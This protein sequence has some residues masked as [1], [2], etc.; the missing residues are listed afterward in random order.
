MKASP[1]KV[2]AYKEFLHARKYL[3]LSVC[4]SFSSV[5][6]ILLSSFRSSSDQLLFYK[7]FS[8][9]ACVFSLFI[10]AFLAL[11][12]VD[13]PLLLWV[14]FSLLPPKTATLPFIPE[15]LSLTQRGYHVLI[16]LAP[17]GPLLLMICC[18]WTWESEHTLFVL[19][20]LLFSKSDFTHHFR[21]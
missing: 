11:V 6:F 1:M 2:G 13:Q 4:L 12:S 5:L 3:D 16:L 7:C 9:C 8:G 10:F 20:L 17:H 18:Y 21:Q 19:L 14:H 15:L